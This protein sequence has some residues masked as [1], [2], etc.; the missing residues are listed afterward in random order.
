MYPPVVESQGIEKFE[1]G[2]PL[3]KDYIRIIELLP[4]EKDDT[5]QCNLTMELRQDSNNSYDA[6]SYAWGD[7]KDTVEIICCGRILSITTSLADALRTIRTRNPKISH[8]LWADAICINQDSN[9]EKNLQVERIGQVYENASQVLA[10]LGPDK[11]NIALDCFNL[12]K[13][14]NVYLDAKLLEY[15]HPQ[16]IPPFDPPPDICADPERASKLRRLM[17]HHWF[18]RVWVVQ[19]AGLAKECHLLWGDQSMR[20]AELV[21]FACFCDGRANITRLIGGNDQDFKIWDLIFRC[22]YRTYK[23]ENSWKC[24][25]PLIRLLY[26]KP[27]RSRGLFLDILQIS[28]SLSAT[29]AR[30]HIYAFLGNP[31]ASSHEGKLMLEPNYDKKN[32]KRAVY[33]D[34]AYA[35]LKN[36]SEAPFVLCFVD[37]IFANEVTGS[38]GPSWVPRWE[39]RAINSPLL[40]SIGNVGVWHKAGGEPETLQYHVQSGSRLLTL[41][42]FV[43]D[44]LAWT[45]ELLKSQNFSLNRDRWDAELRNSQHIYIEVLWNDVPLEIKQRRS[46]TEP[47]DCSRYDDEF[48]FTLVAGYNNTK[49]TPLKRHQKT[50]EAY[51]EALRRACNLEQQTTTAPLSKNKACDASRY[52]VQTRSCS[53]RRLATT[54][55]QRFALVPQCAQPGDV[56]CVFLGL[57]TPFILRPA[58]IQNDA[59]GRFYHIVGEAYV[60]GVMNGELLS[61]YDTY[62]ITLM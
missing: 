55:F 41:Q 51:L 3:N 20:I 56:C 50:I 2:G 48:S 59:K 1:Y 35:L 61:E 39:N 62:P 10:W 46:P 52:E 25:K 58:A 32:N 43:F 26:D 24:S 49:V 5:M 27:R 13:K 9:E 11:D 31:L 36:S 19:E 17:S 45:S 47:L 7:P 60:H 37:H 29:D 28:K 34:I 44:H 40:F 38:K 54:K 6:I 33:F 57:V 14:C 18:S 4:G 30:D 53:N 21:E 42:G 8:R 16:N 23:N 12:I 15:K 22:V